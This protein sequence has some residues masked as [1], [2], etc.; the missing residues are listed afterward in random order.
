[1]RVPRWSP[2]RRSPY[3]VALTVALSTLLLATTVILPAARAATPV[4]VVASG[5][6]QTGFGST[7]TFDLTV[8]DDGAG[9]VSGWLEVGTGGSIASGP[10]TCL[11]ITGN[12]VVAGGESP[13]GGPGGG[14][15]WFTVFLTDNGPDGATDTAA[16]DGPT[17]MASPDCSTPSPSQQAL[18]YG[19]V[20]ILT[21]APDAGTV[22]GQGT[23][24]IGGFA[25][26]T[27][28]F[29]G[30]RDAS[31]IVTGTYSI[32][33]SSGFATSGTIICLDIRGS[34]ATVIGQGSNPTGGG[35]PYLYAT[36]FVDDLGPN[37]SG[38]LISFNAYDQASPNGCLAA[39][40]NPGDPLTGGDIDVNGSGGP[41]APAATVVATGALQ[42]GPSQADSFHLA[43][44][45]DGAG[46][47]DGTIQMTRYGSAVSGT[48]ICLSVTG[49]QVVAGGVSPNAGPGGGPLW[50]TLY[51]TDNGPD[52]FLDTAALDGPTN[53]APPDC[54]SAGP[55]QQT[56]YYGQVTI[57][58]GSP[59]PGTAVGSGTSDLGGGYTRTFDFDAL[60]N[61]SGDV[62]G[63]F[64]ISESQGFSLS[65]TVDCLDIR[66]TQAMLIGH[67]SSAGAGTLYATIFVDDGGPAGVGD[68]IAVNAYSS[69]APA[70][71]LA[72]REH[73]VVGLLSGDIAVNA[74]LPPTPSPTSTPGP[75]PTPTPSPS[76]T[77]TPPPGGPAVL[78]PG[79][80]LS[81]DVGGDGPDAG[82]PVVA[83][84]M[85]PDGGLVQIVTNLSTDPPAAGYGLVGQAFDITAPA[86]SAASPLMFVFRLDSTAI[87]SGDT[88][89][90]IQVFRN[91]VPVADCTGS[92]G[93]ADPD[94][95]VDLRETLADGDIQLTVLTSA[96]SLWSLGVAAPELAPIQIPSSVTPIG[97]T[98]SATAGLTDP[99]ELGGHVASWDWGDGTSSTGAIPASATGSATITGNHAYTEPGVYTLT[100]GVAD[101]SGQSA[102]TSYLYVVV[103]DPNGSFA[104]GGG[105]IVP[106]GASSDP[107]DI[108]PGLDG[109]SK[110]NFGFTIKYR[111]GA[112]TTPGGSLTFHYKTGDLDLSSTGLD[113]LVV[114]NQNWAKFRGLAMIK[115][116]TGEYPFRVD[117][118]D[119]KSAEDRFVIKVWSPGADPDHESPL[120]IA[121][122]T[123]QGQV[124]I[125]K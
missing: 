23:S 112:S 114:T 92:P 72:A 77:P 94:P 36:F 95:C 68:T 75:S 121:S 4:S 5:A 76:P 7:S 15:L 86:A 71:C 78:D 25:T 110:A 91:S 70:P 48:V 113:W 17:S 104:T 105:W 13:N 97:S 120:Y 61:E 83:S 44:I 33:E 50:F 28:D 41:P 87:P 115:G 64:S 102:T 11:S 81:S 9:S 52:G 89:A 108:L 88:A 79:G 84:V 46:G 18:Y 47:L 10:V 111:N 38:D 66:G 19:Q 32:T 98:A 27:F 39:Q 2:G 51:L 55:P 96:A 56:L 59:E 85:A 93:V 107:G 29:N 118:R 125:H 100:L 103:Y 3:S 119:G 58:D 26:R 12:Q 21:G 43:A 69:I 123:V 109:A 101:P 90:T 63:T 22:S 8:S 37:G 31:G 34:H 20:T 30:E 99:G 82:E 67:G 24:S 49:N 6:I 14:S 45:S 116:S 65:G 124:T 53:M 122:G 54:S 117:A 80:S 62:S 40:E 16:V 106:G 73:P 35:G 42:T 57:L 1:M 60:L 74:G